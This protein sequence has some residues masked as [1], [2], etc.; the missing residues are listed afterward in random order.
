MKI[1]WFSNTAFRIHIGGQILVVDA[2]QA[3]QG[4]EPKELVSGADLVVRFDD[5]NAQADGANWS[6]RPPERLLDAGESVRP[7]SIWSLGAGTLL[8]DADADHPL[9]LVTGEVPAVGRWAEKAVIVL[10]GERLAERA[11]RLLAARA[12]RL[13]ALAGD[14]AEVSAAFEAVRDRLD[15]AGL[16]ALEPGMAVEV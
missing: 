15:G 9:L 1:T 14:E 13:I 12:P 4:V 5:E 6:P 10:I 7:L 2:D 8:V 3:G 16:V 11:S